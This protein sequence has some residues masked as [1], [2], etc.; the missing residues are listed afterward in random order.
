MKTFRASFNLHRD[1]AF[2]QKGHWWG[3]VVVISKWI[4]IQTIFVQ[5]RLASF[6]EECQGVLVFKGLLV[7]YASQLHRPN[8]KQSIG[9][10]WTGLTYQYTIGRKV[11]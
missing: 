3:V 7:F 9:T 5:I 8:G 4:S 2:I 11:G 1:K 10:F 6:Y